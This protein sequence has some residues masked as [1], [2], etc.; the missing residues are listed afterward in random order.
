VLGNSEVAN[1]KPRSY[2]CDTFF[3]ISTTQAVL[4]QKPPKIFIRQE[5]F[6]KTVDIQVF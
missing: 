2:I 6:F 1:S 3:N 5:L 4:K